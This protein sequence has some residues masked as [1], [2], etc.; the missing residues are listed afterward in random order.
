MLKLVL[1]NLR[2][3]LEAKRKELEEKL[4]ELEKLKMDGRGIVTI[5]G[6]IMF[7]VLIILLAEFSPILAT[8]L[9]QTSNYFT[10]P[11]SKMLLDLIPPTLLLGIIAS[12]MI[13]AG[14]GK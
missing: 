3:K 13:Y 6:L 10:D 9:N 1:D 12:Y 4:K 2:K 7:V 11:I 5:I 8:A 14:V